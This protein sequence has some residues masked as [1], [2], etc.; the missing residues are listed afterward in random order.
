MH[1]TLRMTEGLTNRHIGEHS[2]FCHAV[3]CYVMSNSLAEELRFVF[4]WPRYIWHINDARILVK[5]VIQRADLATGGFESLVS[6]Y[7]WEMRML[8][9]P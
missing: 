4:G 5:L 3:N 8:Q 2:R 1:L 7:S 6:F 9:R